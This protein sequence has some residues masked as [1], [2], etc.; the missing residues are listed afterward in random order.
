MDRW[1][2]NWDEVV[3][4]YGRDYTSGRTL[5]GDWEKGLD[6]QLAR[7][8]QYMSN[9]DVPL[10]TTVV[11]RYANHTKFITWTRK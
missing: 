10:G 11:L 4:A 5:L 7:T 8:G 2:D 6:F 3:P 9:R 1:V